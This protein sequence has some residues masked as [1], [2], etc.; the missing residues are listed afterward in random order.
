MTDVFISYSQDDPE[1]TRELATALA[2][3][4][5]AVWFDTSM[6]SSDEFWRVI[7]KKI[8]EAKAVITIWSE[9]ALASDW[10]YAET[11]L[12]HDMGKRRGRQKLMCVRTEAVDPVNVPLPFNGYNITPLSDRA[13]I[14]QTLKELGVEPAGLDSA[15]PPPPAAPVIAADERLKAEIEA[16]YAHIVNDDDPAL[17]EAFIAHYGP[18]NAFYL[19]LAQKRLKT[20]K[21]SAH[22][23][24]APARPTPA[25]KAE[26]A[27]SGEDVLLRIDPGMHTVGITRVGASADGRLLVTGSHDKT[28]RLW[29]LPEGRLVRTL[30]PPI[31]DGNEGKLYATAIDPAGRWVATGGWD[32]VGENWVRIFDTETGA[33]R[34]RLGPL[35]NVINDIR[36]SPDGRWLAAVVGGGCGLRVWVADTLQPRANDEDYDSGIEVDDDYE[37]AAY[38]IAF[39][40]DSQ[41]I[42]TTCMDGF[43]RLYALDDDGAWSL[44]N[45]VAAPSGTQPFGLAFSSDDACIAVG[46]ID[47][48]PVDLLDSTSLEPLP[49]P[50]AEGVN[51]GNLA[52]VAFLS[53]G[54][55][56]AGGKYDSGGES[57]IVVWDL[58]GRRSTWPG[59][60]DTMMDFAP[61]PGGRLAYAALDPAFGLIEA[62]GRRSLL[63]DTPT[64]DLR[65]KRYE[66]FLAADDGGRVRFGLREWSERSVFFDLAN[67]RL[68]C[69]AS[70]PP[71]L[72]QAETGKI[73]VQGW[74]NT[75]TPTLNGAPIKLEEY[76]AARALAVA[77]DA[78]SFVL[79]ADWSL[80]GFDRDGTQL[81]HRPVPGV[82]WGLNLAR[83][84]KLIIAAYGDGTIRWHR[85]SDGE[86][87]LALFIHIAP[88]F[89]YT[90]ATQL[91]RSPKGLDWILF[92]PRGFYDAS[93]PAAEKLIGWHVNRGPDEA[94][95]FYPAET[96][97][98]A[99]KKPAI[100]DAAFDD[101]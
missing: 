51:L 7:M 93:S 1:P 78:K 73:N 69:S 57:P 31:G 38:G 63:R 100:I 21:P 11:K 24:V 27:A 5:Y 35:P 22:V 10:V 8:D 29:A 45:K 28:A 46:Y 97:A 34:V 33:L 84:G 48:F 12:A 9:P 37:G 82:V 61:L 89:D 44:I 39:S 42:A 40:R 92:T 96:F 43:V 66:H 18:Q 94:A 58:A 56:V 30:R 70:P 67:R 49:A 88:D 19:A 65:G 77:P 26:I 79:G 60:R 47:A 72:R 86:E 87:L 83:A 54:R 32:K 3:A 20:L 55:L 76:E 13:K 15:P 59:S 25:A 85:A 17:I 98:A 99:F 2:D 74:E 52:S 90:S 53:D 4:R 95:D 80:R 16:A 101:L 50:N 91:D 64:G 36:V 81:W 62:N 6:L 23:V 71:G 41:R 68:E 75:I 14:L